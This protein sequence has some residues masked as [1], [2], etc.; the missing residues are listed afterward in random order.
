MGRTDVGQ[1]AGWPVPAGSAGTCLLKWSQNR[2]LGYIGPHDGPCLPSVW[3]FALYGGPAL[4]TA[5]GG[6]RAGFLNSSL[7]R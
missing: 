4:S 7:N 2:M 6:G 1:C 3:G 5:L